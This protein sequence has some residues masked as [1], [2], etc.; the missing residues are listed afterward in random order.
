[1]NKIDD[2]FL[3]VKSLNKAEK[4]FLQLFANSTGGDKQYM[5]L[6]ELL[7]KSKEYNESVLLKRFSKDKKILFFQKNYLQQQ[8]ILALHQL[9]TKSNEQKVEMLL[10]AST[11]FF[12]RTLYDQSLKQILKARKAAMD[13]D[14]PDLLIKVIRKHRDLLRSGVISS[15][16]EAEVEKLFAEELQQVDEIKNNLEYD[17]LNYEIANTFRRKIRA[18]DD[19]ENKFYESLHKNPLMNDLQNAKHWKAKIHFHN[20]RF[21]RAMHEEKPEDCVAETKAQL[22][23]FS[24]NTVR[25]EALPERYVAALYNHIKSLVYVK[26]DEE[27]L[28]RVDELR[29]LPESYPHIFDQPRQRVRLFELS[30]ISTLTYCF[31]SG[32]IKMG[33]AFSNSIENEIPV[34]APKM[35]RINLLYLHAFLQSFY[36][37]SG[38]WKRTLHHNHIV[39]TEFSEKDSPRMMLIARIVQLILHYELENIEL[40]QSLVRSAYRYFL[41]LPSPLRFEKTVIGFLRNLP[42]PSASRNLLLNR[43]Q[44]LK[45]ELEVLRKD[46]LENSVNDFY[47][48]QWLQSNIEKKPIIEF[49]EGLKFGS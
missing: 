35:N 33:V 17:K 37:A 22:D 15:D 41:N 30:T 42:P 19:E 13:S 40:L 18:R 25:V 24:E 14:D 49:T 36:F 8:I 16:Y 38:N 12:E 45:N 29:R 20:A 1:M 47:Y 5:K 28:K 7:D 39:L 32:K 2:T 3:I 6:F 10:H 26:Q 34:Y 43:F 11:L 23:I 4:R 48:I 46:P 9:Y 21:V 44:E 31:K 27:Y